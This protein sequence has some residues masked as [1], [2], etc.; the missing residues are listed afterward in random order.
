MAMN[1]GNR[2][3]KGQ[4]HGYFLDKW[5]KQFGW[6]QIRDLGDNLSMFCKDWVK[7]WREELM[8]GYKNFQQ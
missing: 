8:S 6:L 7:S 3:E 1:C 5:L 2:T 4:R